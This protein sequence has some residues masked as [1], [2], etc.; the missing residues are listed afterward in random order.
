MNIKF[1]WIFSILS[2]TTLFFFYVYQ[3]NV[4]VSQRYLI[5]GYNKEIRDVSRENQELEIK[6]A[7]INSLDK[8]VELIKPLSFEK[9]EKIH[10]IRILDNQ[11]VAK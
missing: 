4:E 3:V 8:V 5:Q 10:Y 2:I 1:F 6:R 9:T 7:Q 11:V